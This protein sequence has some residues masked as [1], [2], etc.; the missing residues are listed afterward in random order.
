M[1]HALEL[2]DHRP[3][4][5]ATRFH[6]VYR[7]SP[8]DAALC[9]SP[10]DWVVL[11]GWPVDRIGGN[12]QRAPQVAGRLRLCTRSLFFEPDDVRVPIVR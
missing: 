1:T 11:C 5:H 8:S 4:L 12:W 3:G 10:Q 7:P 9:W 2:A 6:G